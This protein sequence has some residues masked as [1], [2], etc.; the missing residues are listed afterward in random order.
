MTQTVSMTGSAKEKS[1]A[2]RETAISDQQK[3]G[4]DFVT[5]LEMIEVL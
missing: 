4:E 1:I 2:F 3:W 5:D